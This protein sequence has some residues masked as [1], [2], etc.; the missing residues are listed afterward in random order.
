MIKECWK[1]KK[2]FSTSRGQEQKAATLL[3]LQN[4][5]PCISIAAADETYLLS[6]WRKMLIVIKMCLEKKGAYSIEGGDCRLLSA[7]VQP[8]HEVKI[9]KTL[10][11]L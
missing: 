5:S 8:I 9:K 11:E 6:A 2:E 3:K 4:R 7:T 10:P 1:Q